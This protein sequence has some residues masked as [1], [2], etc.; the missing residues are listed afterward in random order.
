MLLGDKQDEEQFVTPYAIRNV[1]DMPIYV[2]TLING[3][4]SQDR[5]ICIKPGQKKNIPSTI[6]LNR[7][8][9]QS[10]SFESEV[11]DFIEEEE[12]QKK[13][14]NESNS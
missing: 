8:V 2:F 12:T 4:K 11:N 7:K 10:V 1:T 14:S 13:S 9:V 6:D 3:E 5:Q